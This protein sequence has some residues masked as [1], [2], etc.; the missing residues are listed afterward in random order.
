MN[1]TVKGLYKQVDNLKER[2]RALED[3][4]TRT[5][6]VLGGRDNPSGDIMDDLANAAQ[7]HAGCVFKRTE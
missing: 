1:D 4:M 3:V 2:V 6:S 5:I 7:K